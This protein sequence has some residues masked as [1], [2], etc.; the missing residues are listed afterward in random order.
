MQASNRPVLGAIDIHYERRLTSSDYGNANRDS[1]QARASEMWWLKPGYLLE[2]VR[3]GGYAHH[4]LQLHIHYCYN[5]PDVGSYD[6]LNIRY[7]LVVLPAALPCPSF[8]AHT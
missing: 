3:G 6:Q 4:V 2:G 5:A 7:N 1:L 8:H